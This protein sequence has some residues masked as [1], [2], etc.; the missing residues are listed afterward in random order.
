MSA[1]PVVM[2]TGADLAPQALALL[3]EFEIVYAGK[4]P[5]TADMVSLCKHH[6]PVAIVVRYGRVGAEV[7]DAAPAL[8]VISKHSSGT[9][10]STKKPQKSAVL[11]YVRL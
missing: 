8:R 1:K 2:V 11:K 6:N 5:Q 4:S 3:T 10:T 7:M 9:D